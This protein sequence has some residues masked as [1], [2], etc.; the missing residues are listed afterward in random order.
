MFYFHFCCCFWIKTKKEILIL[1]SETWQRNSEKLNVEL[2]YFILGGIS[3]PSTASASPR[4]QCNASERPPLQ[5]RRRGR[6]GRR[7]WRRRGRD[8]P[9]VGSERGDV[10]G[11]EPGSTLALHSFSILNLSIWCTPRSVYKGHLKFSTSPV[12]YDFARFGIVLS[13]ICPLIFHF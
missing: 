7:R 4:N 2:S 12:P 13:P 10:Y 1:N 11:Y 5:R 9:Q 8:L 6:V 3:P